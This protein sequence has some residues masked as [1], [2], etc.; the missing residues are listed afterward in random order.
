MNKYLLAT[1]LLLCPAITQAQTIIFDD[2]TTL[3][4][5]AGSEIYVSDRIVFGLARSDRQ[6]RFE[7]LLPA[8]DGDVSEVDGLEVV[9]S[10]PL[11]GIFVDGYSPIDES[12]LTMAQRLANVLTP[13]NDS[14][15]PAGRSAGPSNGY[16]IHLQFVGLAA[17]DDAMSPD[18]GADDVGD[19]IGG[20]GNVDPWSNDI[21]WSVAE[22]AI[23]SLGDVVVTDAGDYQVVQAA[24]GQLALRPLDDAI[25]PRYE[26]FFSTVSEGRHIGI[27]PVTGVVWYQVAPCLLLE[28]AESWYWATP[29]AR[30]T[31]C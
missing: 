13:Y 19:T 20:Y 14:I 11:D 27:D 23:A 30:P 29:E 18:F 7:A 31:D 15:L 12:G 1:L 6:Y 2:G 17:S 8:G 24:E 9:R 28:D 16:M 10:E 25:S 21:D 4:V 22:T 3:E 5:P 26:Y